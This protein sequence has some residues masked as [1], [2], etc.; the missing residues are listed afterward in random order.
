[1]REC[2]K[3]LNYWKQELMVKHSGKFENI[4]RNICKRT[5]YFE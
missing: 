4:K 3:L 2:M 5:I 1:M